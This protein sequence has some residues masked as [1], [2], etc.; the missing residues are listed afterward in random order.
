MA[1]PNFF[2]KRPWTGFEL[3]HDGNV[4]PCCMTSVSSCGNVNFSSV[5]EIWNGEKF[6]EMREWMAT[7]Q[8]NKMCKPDCPR[9]HSNFEDA[10]PYPV[11]P[12][13]IQNFELSENEIR[14]RSTVLRSK[15]RFWKLTHSTRCNIDCIMC[16]QDRN[17]LRE[18]PEKFYQDILDYQSAIQE[19]QLIGGE[20]LA[21][22]RYRQLLKSFAD[23]AEFPDLTFAFVTNG[24]VHDDNTLDLIRKLRVSWISISVDAATFPTYAII[25][26]GGDFHHTCK[27]IERLTNLGREQ[28]ISV[29][30]SFT[31]MKDNVHETADF[32]RMARTFGVDAI[33]GRILGTKGGQNIIDPELM[34]ASLTEAIAVAS[35]S[36][37]E[38]RIA[39]ITLKSLLATIQK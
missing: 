5:D 9:L 24:T 19:I 22:K 23:S 12:E 15:P 33:F 3:E 28:G 38:M 32:V 35:Q 8:W 27:G 18:L 37:T 16:Y 36:E 20:T 29:L 2:C 39:N 7:G 11:S 21:I 6:R 26:R 10:N 13:F 30:I 14:E 25:R 1:D 34:K 17:D 4:K 31:V